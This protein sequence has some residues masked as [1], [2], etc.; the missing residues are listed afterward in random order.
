M[1]IYRT[2]TSVYWHPVCSEGHFLL[3]WREGARWTLRHH[4]SLWNWQGNFIRRIWK[5]STL[6]VFVSS[7][8]PGSERSKC[9]HLWRESWLSKDV[10]LP[11]LFLNN[12]DNQI[13]FLVILTVLLWKLSKE[14]K[15]CLLFSIFCCCDWSCFS[16]VNPLAKWFKI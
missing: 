3:F 6:W 5:I 8:R 10:N 1:L 9:P 2:T 12:G 11:F 13:A 14:M 7:Y 4:F 16:V 15:I